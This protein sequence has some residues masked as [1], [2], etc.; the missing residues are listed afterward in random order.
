[1]HTAFLRHGWT[2]DEVATFPR[3]PFKSSQV[4]S[5]WTL[6]QQL[7]VLTET[8]IA[9]WLKSFQLKRR[10]HASFAEKTVGFARGP[11][12]HE[13]HEGQSYASH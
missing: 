5:Y 13:D 9:E 12:L 11:R 2:F 10:Q 6:Y 1:M 3:R 8:E 7:R 4:F